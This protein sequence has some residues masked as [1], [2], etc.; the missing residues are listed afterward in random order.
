[1]NYK[2]VTKYIKDISFKIPKAK[3]Y[4]LL[5]KNINNYRV[6]L[7]LKAR[8]SMKVSLKLIPIYILI[9]NLKAVKRL[10]ILK[11]H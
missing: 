10:M 4:Y 6:K 11:Y 9:P 3:T 2:I 7:I 8:R 5:E 1:M